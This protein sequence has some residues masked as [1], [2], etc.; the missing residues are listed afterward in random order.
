[1][2]LVVDLGVGRPGIPKHAS[3]EVDVQLHETAESGVTTSG[4]SSAMVRS[5][6]TFRSFRDLPGLLP[7]NFQ[8]DASGNFAV[9]TRRRDMNDRYR[10]IE[11]V[12]VEDGCGGHDRPGSQFPLPRKLIIQR[13]A[14]VL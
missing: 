13:P 6:R 11:I 8:R 7:R 14:A 10:A 4:A 1:L 12:R 5:F 3:D 9:A 2:H